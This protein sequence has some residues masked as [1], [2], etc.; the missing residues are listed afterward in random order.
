MRTSSYIYCIVLFSIV[1]ANEVFAQSVMSSSDHTPAVKDNLNTDRAISLS[2]TGP[3][4][5]D[6]GV[7]SD[8]YSSP[9]TNFAE[10]GEN[11]GQIA[12]YRK[13][14]KENYVTIIRLANITFPSGPN[15]SQSKFSSRIFIG[16]NSPSYGFK[17][18]LSVAGNFDFKIESV[19]LGMPNTAKM[20]FSYDIRRPL[21]SNKTYFEMSMSK[22]AFQVGI[23]F[24]K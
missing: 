15:D 7:S 24:G 20:T 9:K 17:N 16:L 21:K 8:N 12:A 23:P 4:A 1:V 6:G 13:P 10:V 18:V 5:A 14:A 2:E 3:E 19:I 22:V 11:G